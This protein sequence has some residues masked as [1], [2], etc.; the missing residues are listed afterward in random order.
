MI[1]YL[2]PHYIFKLEK[3][4]NYKIPFTKIEYIE[5]G[6]K[7]MK[8]HFRL[9]DNITADNVLIYNPSEK[10]TRIFSELNLLTRLRH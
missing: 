4:F 6:E 5:Q 7:M 8:I 1:I 3:D 9:A 2:S 10:S